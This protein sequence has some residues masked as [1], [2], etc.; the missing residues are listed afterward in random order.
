MTPEEKLKHQAWQNEK[1][2]A[3]AQGA[4]NADRKKVEEHKRSDP[5]L[6]VGDAFTGFAYE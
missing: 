3:N 6:K 2:Q 1:N 5:L 4:I